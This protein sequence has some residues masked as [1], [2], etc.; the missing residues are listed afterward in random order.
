MIGLPPTAGLR[1]ERL[2][3]RPTYEEQFWHEELRKLRLRHEDECKPIIDR[4]VRLASLHPTRYI[5]VPI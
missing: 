1:V 2:T 5:L 3:D 4:L